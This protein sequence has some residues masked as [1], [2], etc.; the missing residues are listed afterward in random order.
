MTMSAAILA[1][2]ASQRFGSPK[3]LHL[4]NGRPM[5]AVVA[6]RLALVFDDTLVAGWPHDQPRPAALLCYPDKFAGKGALAG[7]QTALATAKGDWVFCCGCDMPLLQQAVIRRIVESVSDE[8][9]LLPVIGG[10]RQPLHALYKR[11][12]LT[13][14]TQ[15]CNEEG[16]SLPLLFGHVRTRHLPETCFQDI[17]D[18]A[19]SFVSI[20]SHE[21]L[22]D[23]ASR[24]GILCAG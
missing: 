20:D 13:S 9:I 5:I 23:H 2:G 12:I 16:S 24:L 6:D 7:I 11:H 4:I 21:K 8:D 19:L 10:I 22:R 18:Y 15:L 1:G 3:A 17:P 14:V